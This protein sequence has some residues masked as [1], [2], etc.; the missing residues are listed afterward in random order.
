MVLAAIVWILFGALTG[1][2]IWLVLR[3][4]GRPRALV[5]A[6][7][8][9]I[10]GFVGGGLLQVYDAHSKDS[11]DPIS[12]LTAIGLALVAVSVIEFLKQK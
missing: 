7:A 1:W 10:S 4:E 6:L 2:I 12:F 5:D 8:G 9:G 3:P 11:F